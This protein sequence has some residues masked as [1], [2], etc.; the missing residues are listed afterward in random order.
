MIPFII[1][2]IFGAFE[3][4]LLFLITI[5]VSQQ[6]KKK[7]KRL[8]FL[9]FITYIIAIALLINKFSADLVFIFCGFI[10]AL[11]LT[12]II[13]YICKL[14]IPKNFLKKIKYIKLSKLH[15]PLKRKSR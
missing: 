12:A 13:I 3:M 6:N 15:F 8:C 4:C 14:Y 11:P 1:S 10:T 5:A 9:K 7:T 2:A